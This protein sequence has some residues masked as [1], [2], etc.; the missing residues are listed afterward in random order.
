[1]TEA[2]EVGRRRPGQSAGITRDRI[3]GVAKGMDP[4]TLT[5]QAV[6]SRL[7]VDR[8]AVVY[9]VPDK[10]TLLELLAA[11][12]F[13]TRFL[14][15]VIPADADWREAVRLFGRGMY[16]SLVASG[17]I[18]NY[19]RMT[20]SV[21]R[22]YM[23]LAEGVLARLVAGGFHETTAARVLVMVAHAMMGVAKDVVMS[24]E[25]GEHPQR[26]EIFR[27]GALDDDL[28][29]IRHLEDAHFTTY[30]DQQVDFAMDTLLKGFEAQLA[31]DRGPSAPDPGA[32]GP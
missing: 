29:I 25:A 31:A 22:G 1:M 30:D 11:D 20:E 21:A 19:F 24:S 4:S 2:P 23:D 26:R 13:S 3:V 17:G 14:Q 15:T 7:G 9:H 27:D 5:V 28:S 12:A 16:D 18:A 10:A 8:K 32:T 6:A